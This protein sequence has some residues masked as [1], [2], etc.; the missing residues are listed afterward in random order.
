MTDEQI[1]RILG[2]LQEWSKHAFDEFSPDEIERAADE[3]ERQCR[4]RFEFT[5]G[6]IRSGVA[7]VRQE[8]AGK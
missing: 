1:K 2:Q 6:E 3:A 7:G 8:S 5:P 4:R